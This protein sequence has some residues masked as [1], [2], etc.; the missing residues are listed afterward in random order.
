MSQYD[1]KMML[2]SLAKLSGEPGVHLQILLAHRRLLPRQ[3][4]VQV[5]PRDRRR[6]DLQYTRRSATTVIVS[7][8]ARSK[9]R[10]TFGYFPRFY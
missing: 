1:S 8:R 3:H 10:I 7:L 5:R 4:L 9:V 6:R 2:A